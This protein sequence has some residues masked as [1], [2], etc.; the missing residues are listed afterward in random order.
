MRQLDLEL[1]LARASALGENIHYQFATVKDRYVNFPLHVPLLGGRK[2]VGYDNQI[3]ATGKYFS[4]QLRQL[5]RTEVG[6]RICVLARLSDY[7]HRL[8]AGGLDEPD[9]LVQG[10]VVLLLRPCYCDNQYLLL[11]RSSTRIHT[12]PLSLIRSGTP[13]HWAC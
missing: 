4:G 9:K 2:L 12:L 11:S 10:A 8:P 7:T 6:F 3:S 5:S 1:S 13:V